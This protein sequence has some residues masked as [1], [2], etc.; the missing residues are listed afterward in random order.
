M[1]TF[2]V[3]YTLGGFVYESEIRTDTSGAAMYWVMNAF[4]EAKNISVVE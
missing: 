2:L 3:R 4:P 1:K